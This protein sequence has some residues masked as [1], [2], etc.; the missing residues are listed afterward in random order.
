MPLWVL[1]KYDLGNGHSEAVHRT[2]VTASA[3]RLVTGS[4]ELHSSSFTLHDIDRELLTSLSALSRWAFQSS[5][6][7]IDRPEY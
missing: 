1:G 3:G 7:A 4:S 2:E 6:Y 5:S